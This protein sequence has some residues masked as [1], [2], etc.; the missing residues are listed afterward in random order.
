LYEMLVVSV[1]QEATLKNA[2][3]VAMQSVGGVNLGTYDVVLH[4]QYSRQL[5]LLNSV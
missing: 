4:R 3:E 5:Q 2:M 1:T